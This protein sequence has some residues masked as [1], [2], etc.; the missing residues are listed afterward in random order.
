MPADVF[1]RGRQDFGGSFSADAAKVVFSATDLN[2]GG[3]G[4]LTQNLSFN[5]TQ[6][7]T[8]LYEI[9]SQ[10]TFYVAG[11]AQGQATMARILGPRPVQLAFYQKY[12]NGCNAASNNI[13][14]VADTGCAA[15][16][17][18]SFTGGVYAFSMRGAVITSIQVTVQAQDMIINESLTM[19]YIALNLAG[20]G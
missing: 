8:R 11:R 15:N 18:D 13:D 20:V 1:S 12:G 2:D 9:G 19:M 16:G 17:A 4:L 7:I 10:K 5:Y 6:S 14:C 3:V